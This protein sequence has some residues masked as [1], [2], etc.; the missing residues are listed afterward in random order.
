MLLGFYKL[1]LKLVVAVVKVDKA[2]I[3]KKVAIKKKN[4][5]L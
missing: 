2:F 1:T 5:K 4:H 3:N